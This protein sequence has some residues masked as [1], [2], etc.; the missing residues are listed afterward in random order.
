M[1]KLILLLAVSNAIC[2]T[3]PTVPL[4]NGQKIP[5]VGFGT[6]GVTEQ[7]LKDAINAG[8]RHIDIALN[9]DDSEV[10]IG[11]VLKEL[12]TNGKVKRDDLFIV[13]KLEIKYH[14]RN[15]VTQGMKLSLKRLQ[16]DYVD[17]YL[18]HPPESTSTHV[19]LVETW[20]G[21][22]DLLRAN[23]TRSIGVTNFDEKQ[24]DQITANG[25][26]VPVTN[27][28][29]CNPYHNQKKLLSYLNQHKI[30]LTA[31]SALGGSSSPNL[32]KD[33]KLNEISKRHNVSVA[34]VLLRYQ[35]ERNV[36]VIPKTN[37]PKYIKENINLFNFKLTKEDIKEIEALNKN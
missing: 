15:E 24:I 17:I 36:I 33:S 29:F 19:S 30:T 34:Q 25:G 7:A 9:H 4:N 22:T 20:Q 3:V 21:M 10:L 37:N 12:I 14:K 35:I 11:K 5:I 8:Y 13:S 31:Y 32:L 26:V 1:I 18:V 23:L 28:V 6:S 2:L 16:L 27:Q